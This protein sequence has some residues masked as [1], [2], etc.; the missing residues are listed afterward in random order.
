VTLDRH[1]AEAVPGHLAGRESPVRKCTRPGED[2]DVVIDVRAV[3]QQAHRDLAIEAMPALLLPQK[4]R[5]GLRDYEKMFC[6]DIESG[7][8]IFAM[9]GI[10]REAGC[11]VVVRP[12]QYVAHV[13][14]LDGYQRLASF[15]DGFMLPQ[16]D[17][18]AH[19]MSEIATA[20]ANRR[21]VSSSSLRAPG[22][23][24]RASS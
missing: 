7:K 9:R 2:I 23:M 21:I 14:P 20:V 12:D 8:D 19:R 22:P 17:Q 13:L 24:P 11:M 6:A 4:G 16:S 1:R 18:D 3:F 10:D 5:Y 15:F